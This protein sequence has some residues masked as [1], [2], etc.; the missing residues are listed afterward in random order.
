MEKTYFD[1]PKQVVFADPDNA[2]EWIC[3]IAYGYEIICVCCGG[4]F[5]IDD[6]IEMAREDGVKCAIYEYEDW[7]DIADEIVGGELPSGLAYNGSNIVEVGD[8]EDNDSGYVEDEEV[9]DAEIRSIQDNL[10]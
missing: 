4:V 6:V 9:S 7:I 2:G 8:N 10:E 1:R 5:D 3:G